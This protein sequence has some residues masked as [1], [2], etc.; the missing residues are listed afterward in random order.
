MRLPGSTDACCS[1]WRLAKNSEQ[2]KFVWR[3]RSKISAAFRL[4]EDNHHL[5]NTPLPERKQFT[6]NHLFFSLDFFQEN[7]HNLT[8]ERSMPSLST[9]STVSEPPRILLKKEEPEAAEPPRFKWG[10]DGTSTIVLLLLGMMAAVYTGVCV[11][12]KV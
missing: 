9:R 4:L 8:Q 5:A 12:G 6:Y 3:M 11:G 2:T 1:I 10:R 7:A